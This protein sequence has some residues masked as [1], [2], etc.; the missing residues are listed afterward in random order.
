MHVPGLQILALGATIGVTLLRVTPVEHPAQAPTPAELVRESARVARG[1]PA[2]DTTR[3]TLLRRI[4]EAQVW[5]GDTDSALATARSTGP[6]RREVE[7][8]A[9]CRLLETDRFDDAY[10][11]VRRF[12]DEDRDWALAHLA[13][14][15]VR[16]PWAR[17]SS[18]PAA[19]DAA[20]LHDRALGIAREIRTPE[21]RLDAFVSLAYWLQYWE[22][23]TRVA[24]ALDDAL[25]S[26]H[27]V[28]DRDLASSRLRRIIDVLGTAGRTDTA[29][30]LLASLLPRDRI[31]AAWDMGAWRDAQDQR[32]RTALLGLIPRVDSVTDRRVRLHMVSGIVY[33]FNTSRDSETADSVGL[34]LTNDPTVGRQPRRRH[35]VPLSVVE[36]A[37]R[38]AP[39]D[40]GGAIAL[41]DTLDDPLSYGRRARAYA[42]V[43]AAAPNAPAGAAA[44]LMRRAR[45]HALAR[46]LSPR[47]LTLT[48]LQITENQIARG[49]VDDAAAT[50]NEIRDREVALSAFGDAGGMRFKLPKADGQRF[51]ELLR[52]P[53]LRAA[54]ATRVIGPWI[55]D[56]NTPEADLAWAT[57]V[58]DSL[59][60][61]RSSEPAQ[62]LVARAAFSRGDTAAAR[63]RSVAVLRAR[64]RDWTRWPTHPLGD[65]LLILAVRAGGVGEALAWAR[66]LPSPA[67]Q[68]AALLEIG[69]A[70]DMV[71]NMGKGKRFKALP[72]ACRDQF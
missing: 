20:P 52:D 26:L 66:S 71:I 5:I 43:L 34:R 54:V 63:H 8:E 17:F 59:L 3:T 64:D 22:D 16:L 44:Q 33:A 7:T 11:L 35:D 51:L 41:V 55:E 42:R 60:R 14:S 29:L 47:Q 12:P 57:N 36:R 40:L 62:I 69:D 2:S 48:L 49:I 32:V 10:R 15:L 50:L 65:E 13:S 45:E 39:T 31:A 61:G 37:A 18:I 27:D 4:A 9:S 19:A 72:D 30:A 25:A 28:R 24:A 68:A 53:E 56:R 6:W 38:L 46:R 58:A 1:I 67:S 23:T 21:A 70:L